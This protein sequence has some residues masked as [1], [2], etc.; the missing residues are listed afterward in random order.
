MKLANAALSEALGP[1]ANS[2]GAAFASF[3]TKKDISPLPIPRIPGGRL[4]VGSILEFKA[5]GE[6]SSLTGA[7]MGL[8]LYLGTYDDA[9]ASVPAI[10]T[11]IVLAAITTGT[12][13][14]AWFWRL[15]GI[16]KVI[17]TGASGSMVGG[18]VMDLGTSL[19]ALTTSPLPITAVART[20]AINTTIDNR[21]G[22]SASWG[23]SSASNTITTHLLNVSHLN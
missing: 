9:S 6:Y 14:A 23:A 5:Q 7:A 13:P 3:T 10:T 20:V 22:V 17:K 16:Y 21:V 8:G 18:C 4:E 12:T 2:I 11:D 1:F 19:T 15:H